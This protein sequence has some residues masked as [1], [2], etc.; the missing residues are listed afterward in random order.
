MFIVT[1]CAR[2]GWD[3]V[4]YEG[5]RRKGWEKQDRAYQ[6]IYQHHLPDSCFLSFLFSSVSILFVEWY[7]LIRDLSLDR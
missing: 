7:S 4:V 1:M 5:L 2:Y 6:G 3:F